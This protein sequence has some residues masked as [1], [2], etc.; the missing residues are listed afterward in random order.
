MTTELE[1]RIKTLPVWAR[2]MIVR[3]YREAEPN[4]A[5]IREMRQMVANTEAKCRR[6]KERCDAMTDLMT[7]AGRGGHET[8]QAYVDRIIAEYTEG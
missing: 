6:M 7:C 2:A 4:N 1:A 5:E 8:A 3:L